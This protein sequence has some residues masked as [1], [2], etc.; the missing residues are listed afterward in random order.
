[1][2]GVLLDRVDIRVP[3]KPVALKNMTEE[4]GEASRQVR[5][6]VFRAMKMQKKRYREQPFSW[7]S[8]IIPGKINQFCYLNRE[9]RE[10]L[11]GAVS[12]LSLPSR[13]CHSI[14]KLARTIADLK[15]SGI[16]RK[17]HVLEACQHR[18]FGEEDTFWSFG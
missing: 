15:G 11:A 2:G 16:I 17:E 9:C 13:A 5:E 6:R 12:N 7:N 18:W 1:M 3:V 10:A 4:R 8:I 14:M